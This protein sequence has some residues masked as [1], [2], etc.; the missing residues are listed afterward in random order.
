MRFHRAFAHK[1]NLLIDEALISIRKIARR[2]IVDN[3]NKLKF[4]YEEDDDERE[5]RHSETGGERER[6]REKE[7]EVEGAKAKARKVIVKH[8][9]TKRKTKAIQRE[10]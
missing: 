5:G 2:I 3:A 6:E 9:E 1:I 4:N 8:S 10:L 7:E